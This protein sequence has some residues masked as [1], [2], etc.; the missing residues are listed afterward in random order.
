MLT[1][2][3]DLDVQD[4]EV[5]SEGQSHGGHEPHVA[6]GWHHQKGLVLR[7]AAQQYSQLHTVYRTV[8]FASNYIVIILL[9]LM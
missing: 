1:Y 3:K 6:P 5:K 4:N 8:M 7:Q 2:R 9:L